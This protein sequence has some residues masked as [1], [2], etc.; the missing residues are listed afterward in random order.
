MDSRFKRTTTSAPADLG[1][2]PEVAETDRDTLLKMFIEL[3]EQHTSSFTKTQP[4]SLMRLR[5]DQRRPLGGYSVQDVMAEARRHN[6]V[7]PKEAE[8]QHLQ[9]ILGHEAPAALSGSELRGTPP[10]LRRIRLRDQVEWAAEKG[11]LLDVMD[12]LQRLREDQWMHMGS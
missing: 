3:D 10:L 6:R 8:W 7:C 11:R 5:K 4:S 2:L 9:A 1:P 12:F